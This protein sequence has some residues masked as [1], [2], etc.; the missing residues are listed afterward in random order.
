MKRISK[1]GA[2][3]SDTTVFWALGIILLLLVGV[4]IYYIYSKPKDL[5][6]LL[7]DEYNI[8]LAYCENAGIL[9]ANGDMNKLC[10]DY[11]EF[12]IDKNVM[13]YNCQEIARF[14]ASPVTWAKDIN[15][16]SA[17]TIKDRANKYCGILKQTNKL[18]GITGNVFISDMQCDK[19]SGALVG[20]ASSVQSYCNGTAVGA[21][22]GAQ[23][24]CVEVTTTNACSTSDQRRFNDSTCKYLL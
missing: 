10:S 9:I 15:C 4:A 12:S 21:A 1:R 16:G 17:V 3:E 23:N 7:P 8:A 6:K 22:V 20:Y 5:A 19:T 11:K 24:S 18:G 14:S 13:Y 2:A